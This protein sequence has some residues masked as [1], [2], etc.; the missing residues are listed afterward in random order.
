M[1]CTSLSSSSLVQAPLFLSSLGQQGA[2]P[3]FEQLSGNRNGWSR[4]ITGSIVAEQKAVEAG[5]LPGRTDNDIKNYWNSHLKRQLMR[6]GVDPLT[7]RPFQ[8]NSRYH[9]SAPRIVREPEIACSHENV[10]DFFQCPSELSAKSEQVSNTANELDGHP[11]LNLELSITCP[12]I[13]GPEKE[14]VVTPNKAK[15]I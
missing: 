14:D 4:T 6:I 3:I 7:H 11:D 2:L 1:C 5:R 13:H 10:Q 9:P 15:A 12:S 8:K